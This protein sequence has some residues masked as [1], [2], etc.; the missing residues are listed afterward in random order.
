MSSILNSLKKLENELAEQS[1]VQFR[2]QKR[3]TQKAIHQRLRSTRFFNKLFFIIFVIIIL[4]VGRWLILNGKP[5][6]NA[7]ALV[8]KTEIKPAKSAGLSEEKASSLDL[9][10][11]KMSANKDAE[12][13]EPITKKAKMTSIPARNSRENVPALVAKTEIKSAKPLSLHEKKVPIPDLPRKKTATKKNVKKY[14]QNTK[15]KRFAAI[16]VKQDSE[17][18]LKLQAIAWSSDP[19]NRIVV[20]NDHIVREGEFVEGVFV[21]HIGKEEVIFRKERAEWRQLFRIK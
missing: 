17:S 16:P 1:E 8:A 19:K 2:S 15:A 4:A 18:Q 5:G 13:S 20:I 6:K 7:P 3:H 21:T 11:K 9:P 10:Q 12:E 14:E